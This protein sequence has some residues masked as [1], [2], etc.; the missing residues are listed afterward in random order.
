MHRTLRPERIQFGRD[1]MKISDSHYGGYKIPYQKIVVVC[2]SIPDKESGVYQEP[3]ITDITADMEGD[4]ILY[5]S[6]YCR[7]RIQTDLID[8]TAGRLLE[9][10]A[11]LVPYLFMG[12][13]SWL[14]VD[15]E[16]EF[17]EAVRMTNAMR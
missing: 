8:R 4:L 6:D 5:D 3:E 15:N 11:M 10:L 17:G 14:D 13:Q 12:E 9:E 2:L 7:W 1:S 16:E